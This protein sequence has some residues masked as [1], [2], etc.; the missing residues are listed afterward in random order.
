MQSELIWKYVSQVCCTSS[1]QQR[2]VPTQRQT[3]NLWKINHEN[4]S[5]DVQMCLVVVSITHETITGK[6]ECSHNVNPSCHFSHIFHL[7]IYA[8]ICE[9]IECCLN[10]NNI[11]I[12]KYVLGHLSMWWWS[13]Q[14][15]GRS[16]VT[17]HPAALGS[18]K[19]SW[20]AVWC[21][22]SSPPTLA[23]CEQWTAKTSAPNLRVGSK[24]SV[25]YHPCHK[26][27]NDMLNCSVCMNS[28]LKSSFC[29]YQECLLQ[30]V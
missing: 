6:Q 5:N 29:Q 28:R 26:L 3:R 12:K 7:T 30:L 24:L 25:H 4:N 22:S 2:Q 20:D 19:D 13:H 9:I 8:N 18:W 11:K 1:V 23:A 27:P 17:F 16:S 21:V 14:A 15:S 10:N